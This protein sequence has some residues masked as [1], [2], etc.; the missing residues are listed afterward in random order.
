MFRG[1]TF[2][3]PGGYTIADLKEGQEIRIAPG[4]GHPNSDKERVA[5]V[6]HVDGYSALTADGIMLS[7]CDGDGVTL[8]GK[9]YPDFELDENAKRILGEA[10]LG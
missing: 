6:A 9:E 1:T 3:L 5:I 2:P 7:C 10:G 4:C 8:T